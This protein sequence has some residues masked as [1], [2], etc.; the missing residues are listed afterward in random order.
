M[1]QPMDFEINGEKYQALPHT[2]FEALNLDRKVNALFTS[3]FKAGAGTDGEFYAAISGTLAGYSDSDYM[4]LVETTFNRCTVVTNGKPHVR[5]ADMDAVAEQ[6]RGKG[7]EL[8]AAMLR[9][10]KGERLSPFAL[11][12]EPTESGTAGT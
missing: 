8:Y 6:F 5:L 10:W 9:I 7:P 3:A 12:P 11:S 2:G 4:W 1:L